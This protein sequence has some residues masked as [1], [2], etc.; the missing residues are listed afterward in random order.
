VEGHAGLMGGLELD[1]VAD[2][3]LRTSGDAEA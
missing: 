2:R 3:R 1:L